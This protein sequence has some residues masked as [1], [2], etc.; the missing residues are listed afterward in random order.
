MTVTDPRPRI[1]SRVVA[2][3]LL[4][5]SVGVFG[6]GH[7]WCHRTDIGLSGMIGFWV[8]GGTASCVSGM[9]GGGNTAW[10]AVT[11]VT[12]AVFAVPM[13]FSAAAAARHYNRL[14]GAATEQV[15]PA[16]IER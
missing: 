1:P 9:L 2:V 16:D 7:F 12:V 6:V 3:E 11:A 15:Q 10:L 4:C 13:G 8:V 5:G 14:L